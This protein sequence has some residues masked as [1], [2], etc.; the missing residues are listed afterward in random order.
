MGHYH[1]LLQEIREPSKELRDLIPEV[2]A[3][4][5]QTHG[6]AYADGALPGSPLPLSKVARAASPA[7][8][9]AR[10]ARAQRRSRSPR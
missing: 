6:A 2:Y 1:E 7:M 5:A 4:F 10:L 9:V 3:G 8:L